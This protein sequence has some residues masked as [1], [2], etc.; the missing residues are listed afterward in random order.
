VDIDRNIREMVECLGIAVGRDLAG[1]VADGQLLAQLAFR[2]AHRVY[3]FAQGTCHRRRP[4]NLFFVVVTDFSFRFGFLLREIF[5]AQVGLGHHPLRSRM[6]STS[7][8]RAL[9]RRHRANVA[10]R[11]SS[12]RFSSSAIARARRALKASRAW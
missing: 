3:C 12:A 11:L 4:G 10:R 6:A 7:D 8:A 2:H 9:R 5:A 1:A